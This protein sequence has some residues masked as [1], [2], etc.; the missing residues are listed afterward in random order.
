MPV[1]ERALM[2]PCRVLSAALCGETENKERFIMT[3]QVE[4]RILR[5]MPDAPGSSE[6]YASENSMVGLT[7]SDTPPE[8]KSY[9]RSEHKAEKNDTVRGWTSPTHHGPL[10]KHGGK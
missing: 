5:P 2:T 4:R 10:N 7:K 1:N 9:H 3:T 6:H 8:P